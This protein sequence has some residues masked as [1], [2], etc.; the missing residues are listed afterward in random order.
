[1]KL[2]TV[3]VKVATDR[4]MTYALCNANGFCLSVGTPACKEQGQMNR[5]AA[6]SQSIPHQLWVA[7]VQRSGPTQLHSV[8]RMNLTS[9]V[10]YLNKILGQT[11]RPSLAVDIWTASQRRSDEATNQASALVIGGLIS[12]VLGGKQVAQSGRL[13]MH[14]LVGAQS[15]SSGATAFSNI[16]SRSSSS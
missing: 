7:S 5:D 15:C 3:H 14:R 2:N 11:L 16:R 4:A 10:A 1:M 9:G 13:H 12:E 6:K 8:H